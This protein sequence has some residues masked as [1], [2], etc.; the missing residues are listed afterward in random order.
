LQEELARLHEHAV[1]GYPHEV[2]GI[3]AG[4]ADERLVRRVEPLINER[5]EAPERR[6]RVG[7]LALM[8]AEQRLTEA[9]LDVLGYYHSHPDHPASWSDEDR[10]Q[11]IPETSYIITAVHRAPPGEEG[12]RPVE[13]RSWRLPAGEQAMVLEPLWIVAGPPADPFPPIP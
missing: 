2:V 3:L 9:G 10:D 1:Q 5:E 4:D 8:R 13:T 12:P 6:F 7:P 11:A